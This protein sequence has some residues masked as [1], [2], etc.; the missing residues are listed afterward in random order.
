MK[1]ILSRRTRVSPSSLSVGERLAVDFDFAFAGAVQPADQIQQRRF[2][3]AGGADN[4]YHF[5]ARDVQ[6]QALQR[7][8]FALALKL[9]GN[10]AEMDHLVI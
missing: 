9:L 3:G 2:S 4:G 6:V 5:A 1:P 8:H 7:R 10:A